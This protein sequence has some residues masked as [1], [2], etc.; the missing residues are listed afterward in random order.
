[1]KIHGI[2]KT[3]L[4]DYPNLIAC[5]LFTGTCSFRCPF[6]YNGNLVLHP[7]NEPV[8]DLDVLFSF[9]K[10][11]RNVLQGV[12]IGGGEP[13]LQPDLMGFIYKIKSFGYRVKIDTNGYQPDVIQHLLEEDLLDAIAMDIK[14]SPKHYARAAG[15]SEEVFDFLKI[16][17]SVN[18]IRNHA[19]SHSDFYYEFRTTFAKN[20]HTET[21]AEEIGKWLRNVDHYYIQSYTETD[22]VIDSSIEAFS[23]EELVH[24]KDMIQV[25]VPSVEIRG[26]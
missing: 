17:K 18:L 19:E 10:K 6:C 20:L 23:Q 12:C 25:Y 3:T 5:T 13:T 15:V 9:L 7:E 1:M 16:S 22:N 11:R 21:D 26:R 4:L 14:S 8:V 2:K 24:L